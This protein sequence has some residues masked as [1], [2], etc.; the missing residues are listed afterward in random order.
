MKTQ[1]APKSTKRS[2]TT[3]QPPSGGHAS[4]LNPQVETKPPDKK[5]TSKSVPLKREK[6]DIF[7]SFSKP[8]AKL[9]KED[10]N[11]SVEGSHTSTTVIPVR[12]KSA[13]AFQPIADRSGRLRKMTTLMVSKMLK[14]LWY[15]TLT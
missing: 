1:E 9:N 2:P 4:T 10:S 7:K 12:P 8:K 13:Q 15:T 11:S 5:A 3:S 14:A 6:S